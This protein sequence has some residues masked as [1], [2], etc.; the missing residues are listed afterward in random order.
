MYLCMYIRTYVSMY[1]CTYVCM[2]VRMYICMY[3]CMQVFVDVLVC[4]RVCWCVCDFV[5]LCVCVC[6]CVSYM[7]TSQFIFRLYTCKQLPTAAR[8]GLPGKY[9]TQST[10]QHLGSRFSAVLTHIRQ[11]VCLPTAS[12]HHTLQLQ[13]S[14]PLLPCSTLLLS[15]LEQQL[16]HRR[17]SITILAPSQALP[18]CRAQAS[19]RLLLPHVLPLQLSTPRVRSNSRLHPCCSR[20]CLVISRACQCRFGDES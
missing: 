18:T 20:E 6:V 17:L 13:R 14:R 3:V 11:A 19:R 12:T 2:Y 15:N 10:L 8:V 7:Y 1:V 5:C 4:L 16:P 9:A